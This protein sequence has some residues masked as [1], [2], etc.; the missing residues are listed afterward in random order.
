MIAATVSDEPFEEL[1]QES[2]KRFKR[3]N[4]NIPVVHYRLPRVQNAF[5]N[6]LE[7]LW[8][9]SRQSQMVLFFDCDWWQIRPFDFSQL[10]K[11]DGKKFIYAAR[12]SARH[13][14]NPKCF[15]CVDIER[16]GLEADD[17]FNTGLIAFSSYHTEVF[18]QAIEEFKARNQ[19]FRGEQS[20]I[21]VAVQE[22][23]IPTRF[24]SSTFNYCFSSDM[25]YGQQPQKK[26]IAIHAAAF[27]D[28]HEKLTALRW[29]EGASLCHDN[30]VK[31]MD[32]VKEE[33]YGDG[34]H[35]I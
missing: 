6:K 13:K 1:A 22:N 2:I 15:V 9:L 4:P 25:L 20:C 11:D 31:F 18:R 27:T 32:Q 21:N 35:Y 28:H 29:V 10:E 14:K 8:F 26:P 30:L 5:I 24:L 19:D 33:H 16:Y 34:P 12:D 7:V 3:F 17:Y 23:A